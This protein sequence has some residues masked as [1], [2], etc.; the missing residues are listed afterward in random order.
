MHSD[1]NLTRSPLYPQ[2]FFALIN[3][4]LVL[5]SPDDSKTTVGPSTTGSPSDT[6]EEICESQECVS[7]GE[8]L[9]PI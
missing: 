1:L 9:I 6:Q 7:A 5:A 8:V 4:L 3:L 2:S